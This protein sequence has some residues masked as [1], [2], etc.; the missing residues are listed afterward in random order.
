MTISEIAKRAGVSNAAVSRYLNSGY[1]SDA[2][3]EAIRKVI[4]E[5]DY[6]PSIQAQFLRTGKTKTI[7]VIL[8]R[9]DSY[10]VS[11]VMSGITSVLDEQGYQLLLVDTHNN[12]ERELR[13]LYLFDDQRV[14]GILLFGSVLTARHI[15]AMN[16]S[17]V[18][19]VVI[20]Q[21]LDGI[22]CVYHNDYHAFYEMTKLVLSK[23]RC[24]IAYMGALL[25][26][27]A[28]GRERLH[29]FCDAVTEAG[30][31][32]LA[33]QTLVADFSISSGSEIAAE[34]YARYPTMDALICAT[35]S[36]AVGALRYFRAQNIRVPEQIM[37]TGQGASDISLMF[38]PSIT[39]IR[40]AYEES[41][42]TAAELLLQRI[43]DP[44]APIKEVKLSYTILE[45]E[46][47]GGKSI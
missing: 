17:T 8:P 38:S 41:G 31:P 20:A 16:R 11:Q 25:K 47:T 14:D 42:S 19:I 18:P 45:H 29:A 36:M 21:Q 39:T 24:N 9:I 13:S 33:K 3:R 1:L 46:S 35:D 6:R 12:P 40:Y 27:K 26:D 43:R 10:S 34:L 5:T 7:G 28:V 30:L 4:E 22:S 37:V 32:E 2:K 44:G 23:G 15:T